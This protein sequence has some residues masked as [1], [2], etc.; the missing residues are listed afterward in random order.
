MNYSKEALNNMKSKRLNKRVMY[1][2]TER[3]TTNKTLKQIGDE[4]G[5]TPER[6]RQQEAL[7]IAIINKSV[8][9]NK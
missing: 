3:L 9:N 6:V 4:L 7:G 5:V 1:I 2:L 8:R